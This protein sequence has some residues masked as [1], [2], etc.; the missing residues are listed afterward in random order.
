MRVLP[1]AGCEAARSNKLR[2]GGEKPER[3]GRE[4]GKL[5]AGERR[6]RGGEAG[7][8]LAGERRRRG[9]EAGKLLAGE[10][11]RRGGEAGKLPLYCIGGRQASCLPNPVG[12]EGGFELASNLY[13]ER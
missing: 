9:G 2:G 1:L 5:L 8:L 11:W 13:R 12:R 10:R 3:R 4:A 7:K 6:R